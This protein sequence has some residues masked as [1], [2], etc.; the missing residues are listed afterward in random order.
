MNPCECSHPAAD[1]GPDDGPCSVLLHPA[2]GCLGFREGPDVKDDR[3]PE[4][5]P[6]RWAAATAGKGADG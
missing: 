4:L 5:T 2:C 3:I 1:H 6:S